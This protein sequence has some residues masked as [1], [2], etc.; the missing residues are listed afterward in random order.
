M[1]AP[2]R[3]ERSARRGLWRAVGGSLPWLWRLM[4]PCV[5]ACPDDWPS[6]VPQP[7]TDGVLRRLA[8]A[9]DARWSCGQKQANTPGL[10]MAMEATFRQSIAWHG[11]DRRRERAKALWAKRPL[12]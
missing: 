3:R 9:A 12:G 2:R 7:P 10:G 1:G 5:A 11:G 4:G 8:A 6:Q